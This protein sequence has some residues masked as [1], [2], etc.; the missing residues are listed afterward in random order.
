MSVLIDTKKIKVVSS[1]SPLGFQTKGGGDWKVWDRYLVL[2]GKPAFHI[3]NIC[4]TCTFFFERLEGANASVNPEQVVEV[5]SQGIASLNDP[6]IE[7]VADIIPKG[8]YLV[9]LLTVK[10]SLTQPSSELDYFSAEQIALWGADG[11]W[12]IPHHPKTEYY[13]GSTQPLSNESCLFEFI[14]PM[15]PQNWLD[16]GR[17]ENFKK[18]IENGIRPTAVAISILDI[19]QPADWDDDIQFSSHWCLAHYLIDGHH[20]MFAA[21]Q[22]DE[23]ITLLSFLALGEGVSSKEQNYEIIE[24]LKAQPCA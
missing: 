17:I 9:T 2:D 16:S 10:P 8:E 24:K 4:E 14:I 7:E 21:S 23:P 20:K 3:G 12:G 6:A 22:T 19:K 1:K 18:T 11:F 13:R 15:F 5:L